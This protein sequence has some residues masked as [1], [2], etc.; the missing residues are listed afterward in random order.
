MNEI[1]WRIKAAKQ[2]RRLERPAQIQVRDAV[3][4][5]RQFPEC[6]NVKALSNHR[7]GY[8]LRVGHYRVLFEFDGAIHVVTI[9]EV[10]KRDE[11]T[12]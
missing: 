4:T 12:Y 1:E 10:R 5:L 11:H 9:E 3:A 6:R 2:L 8:R 7:Y